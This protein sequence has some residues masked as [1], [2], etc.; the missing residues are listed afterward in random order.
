MFDVPVQAAIGSRVIA[1]ETIKAR[2]KDVLAK[3][4]GGDVTRKRK[5]LERQKKGKKRMKQVGSVEVPRRPSSQSSI[6]TGTSDELWSTPPLRPPA[7]LRVAL[8]LL[9]L[10]HARG[11]A[12]RAWPLRGRLVAEFELERGRLA[13]DVETIFIGGGTPTFTE[14]AELRRLIEELPAAEEVTVEAN[15]ETVT[16]ELAALL[17]ECGVTRVS[18]G[19]QS[20]DERLLDV[21]DRQARPEDVRR[22]FY[23]LRDANFDNISLDLIYGIPGQEPADLERDLGEAR[24]R[25]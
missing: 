17:R 1:R 23:H 18:L 12:R 10:R 3:C 14:P 13:D 4:Y 11:A 8:W 22:A 21:L 5:L 25:A 20:F 24:S 9:R 2:R 16:P 15:P 19:A 6:S 7:V